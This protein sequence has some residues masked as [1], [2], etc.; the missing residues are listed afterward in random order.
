MAL[1]RFARENLLRAVV[2]MAVFGVHSRVPRGHKQRY[3]V[4]R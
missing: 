4:R 3:E 2:D 1:G